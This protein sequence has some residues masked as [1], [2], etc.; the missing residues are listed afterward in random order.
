M[1]LFSFKGYSILVPT[2]YCLS[3]HYA[4]SV[5]RVEC[6]CLN[7]NDHDIYRFIVKC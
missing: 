6:G 4:V 5:I 7:N 2:L 1:N 3:G